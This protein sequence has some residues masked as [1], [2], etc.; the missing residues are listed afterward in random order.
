MWTLVWLTTVLFAK[1]DGKEPTDRLVP[2]GWQGN[3]WGPQ[4]TQ[5]RENGQLPQ[6]PFT[7]SMKQWTTWGKAA[8]RDGDIVF[9]RADAKVLFGRFPFSR[10]VAN[11]SNSL[12]S[13]TGIVAIEKGEPVVYDTTKA[14]VRR[15]PFAVWMLDNVGAFGVKRVRRDYQ[16]YATKAVQF[17]RDVYQKQVPF[18]Y[19]LGLDDRSL[20]CV[21]MTEKAYRSAGLKLSDPIRLGDMERVAEFPVCVFVFMQLSDLTLDQQ[22]YFPGNERHGIWSCPQ[23][24]TVYLSAPPAPVARS[25]PRA[26][27]DSAGSA[28]TGQKTAVRRENRPS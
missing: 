1:H 9:R 20:Y 23:L 6:I 22:V 24:Q 19:E 18:D 28:S 2:P 21:E 5:A 3:P 14:G 25:K 16:E 8:L 10:F 11:A 7:P 15:Q 17:C 12:F 13:H 4:A 26:G 27:S